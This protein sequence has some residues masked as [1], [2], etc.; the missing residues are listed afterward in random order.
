VA[1]FAA[2]NMMIC[3]SDSFFSGSRYNTGKASSNNAL[4]AIPTQTPMTRWEQETAAQQSWNPLGAIRVE[5]VAKS[6]HSTTGY[7]KS[8]GNDKDSNSTVRGTAKSCEC[9]V[10]RL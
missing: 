8:T 4:T 7:P 5:S 9:C 6:G 2:S 3:L 10:S 1:C